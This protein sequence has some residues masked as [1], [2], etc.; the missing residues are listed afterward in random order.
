MLS[1]VYLKCFNLSRANACVAMPYSLTEC[2]M[3]DWDLLRAW[4]E[5][6][7]PIAAHGG[8]RHVR[9]AVFRATTAGLGHATPATQAVKRPSRCIRWYYKRTTSIMAN[10]DYGTGR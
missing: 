8:A 4:G 10:R 1:T 7:A 5:C 3:G 2:G 6:V 9:Q